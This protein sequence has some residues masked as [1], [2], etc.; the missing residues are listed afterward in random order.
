MRTGTLD[1]SFSAKP[2]EPQ[3]A[4]RRSLPDGQPSRRHGS[5][6]RAG[7]RAGTGNRRAGKPEAVVELVVARIIYLSW[8]QTFGRP[9]RARLPG[10][11]ARILPFRKR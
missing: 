9:P 5:A 1:V 2:D 8:A 3:P 11:T 4:R 6:Q 10:M 7:L